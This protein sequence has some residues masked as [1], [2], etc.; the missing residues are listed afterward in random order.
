M[1]S[2][3]S[4]KLNDY[5][6]WLRSH[7]DH[8]LDS[9][10]TYTGFQAFGLSKVTNWENLQVEVVKSLSLTA[11]QNAGAATGKAADFLSFLNHTA[12]Q[13]RRRSPG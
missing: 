4:A 1:T 9:D 12:R 5:S 7:C 3:V 8:D 13:G 10:D 2:T 6:N 11:T